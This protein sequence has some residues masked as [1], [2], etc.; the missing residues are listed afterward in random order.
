MFSIQVFQSFQ[1]IELGDF[2]CAIS[3]IQMEFDADQVLEFEGHPWSNNNREPVVISGTYLYL[4]NSELL[5]F[6]GITCWP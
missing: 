6:N 4:F 2:C 1:L 3:V 5:I